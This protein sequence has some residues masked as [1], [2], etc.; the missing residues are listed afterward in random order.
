MQL[1]LSFYLTALHK[2]V[3]LENIEIVKLLLEHEKLDI[4]I[5]DVFKY[6]HFYQI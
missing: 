2:A 1:L 4:N 3:N 5:Y 6:K